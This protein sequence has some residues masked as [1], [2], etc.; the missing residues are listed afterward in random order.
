MNIQEYIKYATKVLN[1]D[2]GSEGMQ[3]KVVARKGLKSFENEVLTIDEVKQENGET[4]ARV[5]F[6]FPHDYGYALSVITENLQDIEI[7]SLSLTY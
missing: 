5:T 6:S 7:V 3:Y 1:E 4:S 2:A